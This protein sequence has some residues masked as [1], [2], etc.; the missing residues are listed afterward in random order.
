MKR[1]YVALASALAAACALRLYNLTSISLWHDEAFSALLIKYPWGEM[2]R[3]IGLDVHPP[4]YY[5]FLKLWSYLFGA[6]ILA[7]RGFSVLM[8][9]LTVYTGYLFVKEAF[10][11]AGEYEWFAVAVAVLLA[12]NPFQIEL[13]STDARMYSMGTF[14]AL[15]SAFFLIKAL[16]IQKRQPENSGKIWTNWILFAVFVSLGIYTHYYLLFSAFAFGIF[17]L[18]FLYANYKLNLSYYKYF[19]AS[20]ILVLASFLPWLKIFMF[21]LNQVQNNYWIPKMSFYGVLGT[22]WR[23]LIGSEIDAAKTGS[24]VL[25]LASLAFSAYMLW[26]IAK[27]KEAG[28]ALTITALTVPFVMAVLLSLKQSIFLARY[29]IFAGVFYTIAL[30]IFGFSLPNRAM[31]N[32][33]LTAAVLV[34]LFSWAKN[35]KD[36]DVG[37]KP[38]MAGAAKYLNFNV[39]PKD[40]LYVSS[41][42]EFFNFRYYNNTGHNARLYDPRKLSQIEHFSG[43]AL[44][45]ETDLLH[46]WIDEA[47]RGDTVWVIWTNAFGGSRPNVPKNWA[48]KKNGERSF[49]DIRPYHGTQIIVHE[50][51][52]R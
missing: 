38:G 52:V 17:G 27:K 47:G 37:T 39:K 33:L 15:M 20:W 23:I 19:L 2:I 26:R 16:N 4:A 40:K 28:S 13:A 10:K 48:L 41:S 35:W 21:Q 12:V 11:D 14:T 5:V 29:F 6:S 3:R 49:A 24:K 7:L 43:T 44:L 42:F 9:I 22:V 34:S 36:L 18:L 51:I 50:Y 32:V 30:C 25:L 45:D 31:R 1:V 8:G 46:S